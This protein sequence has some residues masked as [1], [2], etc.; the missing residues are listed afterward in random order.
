MNVR[1]MQVG[2]AVPVQLG[3]AIGQAILS[4]EESQSK[5]RGQR[6]PNIEKMMAEAVARL[7]ASARN[8]STEKHAA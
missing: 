7:R 4:H 5:K 8:K 3:A 1:Y 6:Q 2:N